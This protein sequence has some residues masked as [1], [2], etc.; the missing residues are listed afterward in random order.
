MPVQSTKR[1]E[2][3]M[4]TKNYS[5][6]Q[7]QAIVDAAPLDFEK[8][9]ALAIQLDKSHRSVISKAKS[10]GVEYVGKTAAKKRG[11]GKP[12]LVLAIAKSMN[13]DSD[14]LEG[15]ERATARSLERLLEHMA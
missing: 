11:I 1:K 15:L 7:V 10:L 4:A 14:H 6:T 3:N 8:A 5:E 2:K 9:Q 12:D 13:V